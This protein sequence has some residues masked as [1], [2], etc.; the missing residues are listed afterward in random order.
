MNLVLGFYLNY[1]YLSDIKKD[2]FWREVALKS[3]RVRIS[4]DV[5]AKQ[6]PLELL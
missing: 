6:T 4:D 2:N 3:K 5:M 1:K